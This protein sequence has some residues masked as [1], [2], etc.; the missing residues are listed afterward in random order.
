M[1]DETLL[2]YTLY[3]GTYVIEQCKS[4]ECRLPHNSTPSM[5][6]SYTHG[7][8]IL[9]SSFDG[10]FDLNVSTIHDFQRG[11]GMDKACKSDSDESFQDD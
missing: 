1:M 4:Y 3:L 11:I 9:R 6:M 5:K 7:K 8:N 10:C 2:N